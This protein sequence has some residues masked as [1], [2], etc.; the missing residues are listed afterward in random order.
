MMRIFFGALIG[1][2]FSPGS[3]LLF[4]YEP[5]KARGRNLKA[6]MRKAKFG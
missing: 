6:F 4:W 2:F 1:I 5:L 3:E